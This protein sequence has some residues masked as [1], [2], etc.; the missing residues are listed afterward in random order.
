MGSPLLLRKSTFVEVS[1]GELQQEYR[2]LARLGSGSFGT[3]YKVQHQLSGAIFAMKTIPKHK[4]QDLSRLQCEVRILREADLPQIITIQRVYEDSQ[5]VN[6]VMELCEGGDLMSF[7][8]S[9]GGLTELEASEI[10][11][12]ILIALRYLHM[13]SIGHRDIKPENVMFAVQ[14]DLHS[15]KLIDFGLAKIMS[16]KCPMK[17]KVGTTYYVSPDVLRGDYGLECDLWS[18]GVVLYF[19]LCGFPP[20]TGRSASE[21][22]AKICRGQFTFPSPAWDSISLSAKDLISHLLL[23]D[24]IARLT[25][26]TALEHPWLSGQ[27][28]DTNLSCLLPRM[29]S[30]YHCE[31]L[32]KAAHLAVT[33]F[34]TQAEIMELKEKFEALDTDHDGA[35]SMAELKVGLEDLSERKLSDL[36]ASLDQDLNG[37][38]NYS[39][40]IAAALDESVYLKE[41]KLW[42]TFMTFDQD[43]NGRITV[44][45]LQ[46]V[47]GKESVTVEPKFWE[48]L[49]QQADRNGDGE[50]DFYEFMDMMR[51]TSQ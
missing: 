48:T 36:V 32:R 1:Q 31:R 2:M 19:M 37:V 26:Q 38:V 13:H 24:P 47:L 12:Q 23:L 9:K 40:F 5:N 33:V 29:N 50:I 6:L 15:L 34:C 41:E 16:P 49:M 3:V 46:E 35:I 20:F 22:F 8:M 4:I 27:V 21:V 42:S 11:R 14:G 18:F 45:E 25:A 44:T 28:S 17:T 7:I 43:R 51:R 10:A 30:F 39:E